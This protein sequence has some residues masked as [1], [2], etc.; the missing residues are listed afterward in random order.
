MRVFFNQTDFP[1]TFALFG[2]VR[3]IDLKNV[4]LC[5]LSELKKGL[6][7]SHQIVKAVNKDKHFPLLEVASLKH[8]GKRMRPHRVWNLYE[9]L[10]E[11]DL[12]IIL[13]IW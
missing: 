4:G 12:M 7:K 6:C 8:G 1:L 3:I 13:R 9:A 2:T 11:M 10:A 5:A